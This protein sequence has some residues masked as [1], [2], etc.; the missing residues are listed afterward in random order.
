MTHS[1]HDQ[2]HPGASGNSSNPTEVADTPSKSQGVFPVVVSAELQDYSS[3]P[4]ARTLKSSATLSR[5]S[6]YESRALLLAM[7]YLQTVPEGGADCPTHTPSLLTTLANQ[8]ANTTALVPH[9]SPVA[10]TDC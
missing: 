1:A 7:P 9:Q 8:V 4:T 2:G 5:S 3:N 6:D 10:L